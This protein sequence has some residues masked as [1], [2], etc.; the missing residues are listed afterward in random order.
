V[1]DELAGLDLAGLE[2]RRAVLFA[3]LSQVGDFRRGSLNAVR[4]K[5]GKANCVCAAPGHAGHGPQYNLTRWVGGKTV[6][7][8]V[9]PGPELDKTEREV[10]AWARFQGLVAAIAQV[11]EAICVA[12]PV[13]GVPADASPGSPGEKGGFAAG[14]G[15]GSKPVSGRRPPPRSHG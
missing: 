7:V 11:N 6:N 13:A 2:A 8:R 14:T 15:P 10:A 5:C 12:R 9:R 4:R 1:V 3:E